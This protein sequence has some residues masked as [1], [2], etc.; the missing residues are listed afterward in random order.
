MK[1]PYVVCIGK[2]A[3]D[4]YYTMESFPKLGEKAVIEF[5]GTIPGGFIANAAAVTGK[6]G[7]DCYMIDVLGTDQ[8]TQALLNSMREY[9]VKTDYIEIEEGAA[10]YKTLILLY[11]VEKTILLLKTKKKGP[12][13]D[14]KMRA[15]LCGA[16]FVYSDIVD[17]KRLKDPY[18]VIGEFTNAGA[19]LFIDAETSTFKSREIDRFFFEKAR[20]ISLNEF[21]LEKYCKNAGGAAL[22]DLLRLDPGK[23][24]LVTLGSKGCRILTQSGDITLDAYP[25]KPVDTTGAG[26]TFNGAFMYGLLSGWTIEETA[27]FATAAAARCVLIRGP[28][29]GA[30][31]SGEVLRFMGNGGQL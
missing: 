26:D 30:V 1:K 3:V 11:G 15:L 4:E 2:N 12:T 31:S 7:A 6:L 9:N 24:I 13:V 23:I 29:S 28:R 16:R 14:E 18:G 20:I 27:K 8:Y 21:A 25:V 19:D 10:N 22:S 5:T 17:L